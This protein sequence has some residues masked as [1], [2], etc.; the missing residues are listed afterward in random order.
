VTVLCFALN[1]MFFQIIE[2]TE[3]F[4]SYFR[5]AILDKFVAVECRIL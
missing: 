4:Q 3:L 2:A 5:Q 1:D